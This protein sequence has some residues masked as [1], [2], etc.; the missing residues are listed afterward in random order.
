MMSNEEIFGV[1]DGICDVCNV[2]VYDVLTTKHSDRYNICIMKFIAVYLYSKGLSV[3]RISKVLNRSTS[4][5]DHY[6]N[7]FIF[8]YMIN[9]KGIRDK[10]DEF[11]LHK[12]IDVL[13]RLKLC[14][15]FI[16]G[17]EI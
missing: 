10:V 1:I 14:V 2:S 13:K 3:R 7:T 9:Y 5:I 6:L 11:L 12:D 8:D 17:L 16:K 15:L 4:T